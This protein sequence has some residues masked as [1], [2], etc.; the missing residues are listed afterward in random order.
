VLIREVILEHFMS[1]EYARIPLKPGLNI[2]CGPNGSGKSSIL[3]AI[4]V[5]LGQAYTERSRKL[6]D[7]IRWGEDGARVTLVFDNTP[8]GGRRP[9]PR[10]D[11]DYFRISRYLKKDGTYW[12]EVN[13]KT[14][15]KGEVTS[16]LK[17]FGINPDNMLVIM[18][19]R[20]MEEFGITTLIQRLGMVEEAVGL[21]E[22]RKNVLEAQDKL[23]QVL[24]QEEAVKTLLENA[25]QTL[26]YW[27]EEYDK[28][29]R[30]KELLQRKKFLERELVWTQLARQESLVNSWEEKVERREAILADLDDEVERTRALIHKINGDLKTLRFDQRKSFYSLM[31]LEKEK[32]EHQVTSN[33][34]SVTL[35]KIGGITEDGVKLTALDNYAGELR[36][37]ISLSQKTLQGLE[38]KTAALQ[39]QLAAFDEELNQA[40]N[41]YVDERVKNGLL[42]F[43]RET[44]N[45][46]LE[47]LKGELRNAI[48]EEENLRPLLE[49]A[50]APIKSVRSLQEIAD[51]IKIASI[52]LTTIGDLSTDVERMYL[53]YLNVYNELKTKVDV[54]SENR[55][56]ALQAVEERKLRWM[57]MIRSLLKNVSRIYQDFLKKINATGN[58]RLLNAPDIETAGLELTVGFKGA[59]PAILDAYTQSG[60]ERSTATMVF[61]LALQQYVKSPFR[62][63]DEFDI[64]MDPK[65]R[66]IISDMLYEE[67]EG[68]RDIQYL[69]ITPGQ[70]T[71]VDEG[72]H[73]I[74]VQNIEGRSEIQAVE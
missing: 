15:T 14:V 17:E 3:L 21:S 59:E 26:A 58:I 67:I 63:V 5:A 8:K 2:I 57:S 13:F 10:F 7:L 66:E 45:R 38:V 6:S 35:N 55:M 34:S 30:G 61:L 39:A 31:A 20:M 19:Q 44:S 62:A 11:T 48:K 1:Y 60:G 71:N 16:I 54:V 74:T 42:K 46:E 37:R 29:Q 28:Y 18:H 64:H 4:S 22:Y 49:R 43:Q 65:N 41:R 52:Q 23:T 69:T 27:K 40:S 50:G 56:D 72:V 25:D 36:S 33:L 51:D 9:V 24:S 12:F 32:T 53:N 73:V 47:C 68:T 70:I